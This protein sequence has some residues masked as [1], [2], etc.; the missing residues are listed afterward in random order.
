MIY[1]DWAATAPPDKE[2]L[3]KTVKTAS[4][5]RSLSAGD[6]YSGWKIIAIDTNDSKVTIR[7]LASGNEEVQQLHGKVKDKS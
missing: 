7:D 6:I 1:L 2:I 4:G 3:E 5:Y